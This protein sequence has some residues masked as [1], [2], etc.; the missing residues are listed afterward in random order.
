[1]IFPYETEH[2]VT[3][4]ADRWIIGMRGLRYCG[5]TAE[6]PT[7]AA[8]LEELGAQIKALGATHGLAVQVD[9]DAAHPEIWKAEGQASWLEAL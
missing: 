7:L 1:M 9:V 5:I 6:A 8:V 4:V 2:G 3:L